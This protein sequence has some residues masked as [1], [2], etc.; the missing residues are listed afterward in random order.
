MSIPIAIQKS[1]RKDEPIEM[2]GLIFYPVLVEEIEEL[3][4]VRPA[5]EFMQQNFPVKYAAMPLLSAFYAYDFDQICAGGTAS[6]LFLR[7]VEFLCL[8]LRLGRGDRMENRIRRFQIIT[9]ASD[10]SILKGLSFWKDGEEQTLIKPGQFTR[11]RPIL[12]A[13][14]G[15]E[16][17]DESTNPELIQARQEMGSIGAVALREDIDDLISSLA[18]LSHCEEAEIMGWTVR[19]FFRRR[20]AASRLLHFVVCGIGEMSGTKWK[21]GN[22][23]PS[24]CFDRAEGASPLIPMSEFMKSAGSAAENRTKM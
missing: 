22:P 23:H 11:W 14:N 19:K 17:P 20:D 21:G 9:D 24:W 15:M 18:L 4:Q 16:V 7:A 13:Q 1:I 6:G 10:P 12:A 3:S 8:C 2:D 5:V